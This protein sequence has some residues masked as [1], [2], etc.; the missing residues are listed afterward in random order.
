MSFQVR[1]VESDDGVELV[2]ELA[3][4]V[5]RAPTPVFVHGWCGDRRL[6]DPLVASLGGRRPCLRLDLAGHGASGLGRRR[7][8]MEAFG[9]DV[10]RCVRAAGVGPAM[11]VGHSMA[12]EVI[13]EA[14]LELGGSVIGVVGVDA[15]WNPGREIDDRLIRDIL[16]PFRRDYPRAAED[17]VRAMFLPDADPSQI[18][19]LVDGVLRV[20]EEV[21]MGAL[22]EVLRHRGALQRSLRRLGAP[23]FLLNSADWRA[24]D[25]A[26]AAEFGLDVRPIHGVGHFSMIERPREVA[27]ALE[28]IFEELS[29]ESGA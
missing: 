2:Y 5:P 19:R 10:A 25:R 3:A 18:R 26:A 1:T 17:Y 11:L 7:Y 22:E 9:R 20:P 27:A 21:G 13:V 4:G 12:G 15:L 16:G 29:P 24:T 28:E 8:T 6:W 14:A 23:V